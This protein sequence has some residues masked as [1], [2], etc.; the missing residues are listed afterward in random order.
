[1][2]ITKILTYKIKG[3]KKI[4]KNIL[5]LEPRRKIYN[6]ILNHPGVYFREISRELKIPKSTL[7]YHLRYLKKN[8][9]ILAR[10]SG[11]YTRYFVSQ[12]IGRNEKR[13]FSV[14]RTK[15]ALHLV[16]VLS[17]RHVRT[18]TELSRELEKSPSAVLYHLDKLIEAEV[19][20]KFKENNKIKYRLKDEKE[21]DKLLIKHRE[22]LLDELVVTF[23][24]YYLYWKKSNWLKLVIK[25]LNDKEKEKMHDDILWEIFPHPYWG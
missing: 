7:E 11:V 18:R 24:D 8:E 2:Y 3:G 19:V 23:Y 5:Q 17:M 21:T 4:Q 16:L 14:L 10:K 1:L 15:T 6:F 9:L 22:G 20:E 13:A 12:E 25:F